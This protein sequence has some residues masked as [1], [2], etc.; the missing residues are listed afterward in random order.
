M[1]NHMVKQVGPRIRPGVSVA[2]Y[3]ANLADRPAV[4]FDHEE[5]GFRVPGYPQK[6]QGMEM[7]AEAMR[8]SWARREVQG[9]RPQFPTALHGLMTAVRVLPADLYRRVMESDEPIAKGAIFEEIV[10]RTQQPDT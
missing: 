1:M 8:K 6:M 2:D 7:S 9:M 5:R 3:Q 10:R 4:S